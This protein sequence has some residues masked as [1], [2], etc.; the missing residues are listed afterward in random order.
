MIILGHDAAVWAVA[1]LPE[2]GFMITGSADKS[3]KLW[4]AGKCEKTLLGMYEIPLEVI[5]K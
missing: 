4:K 2:G 5:L 3:I 1:I